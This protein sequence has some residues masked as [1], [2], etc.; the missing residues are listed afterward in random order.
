MTGEAVLQA[1][2]ERSGL[3]WMQLCVLYGSE[4]PNLMSL[5]YCVKELAEFGLVEVDGVD[6]IAVPEFIMRCKSDAIC[7]NTRLIRAS[8]QWLRMKH[9]LEYDFSTLRLSDADV[10]SIRVAPMFGKPNT[11]RDHPDVF[12]IMPFAQ[13]LEKVFDDIILRIADDLHVTCARADSLYTANAIIQDVWDCLC[14]ARLVVA[15]CTGRNPNVFY[16]LGIAHTLGK[17]V[18]LLTQSRADVPFDVQH[19]R[20]IEYDLSIPGGVA[21]HERLH[22]TMAAMLAE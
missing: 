19:I 18:I 6:T 7:A 17:R 13:E 15:D 12:V 22:E 5:L 1:L 8:G 9:S 20:Y 11:Y 3:T 4:S 10:K 16:E 2:Y 14:A 21:L